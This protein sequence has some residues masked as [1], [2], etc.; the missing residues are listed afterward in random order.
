VAC[1]TCRTLGP[2]FS[3]APNKVAALMRAPD[4]GL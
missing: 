3:L 2:A 4:P 1:Y